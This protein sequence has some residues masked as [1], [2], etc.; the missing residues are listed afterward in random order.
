MHESC[1]LV[2]RVVPGVAA[3]VHSVHDR[4]VNLRLF[5]TKIESKSCVFSEFHGWL[6]AAAATL[7]SAAGSAAATLQIFPTF[8][9]KHG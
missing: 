8:G 1:T 3:I 2:Q 5:F 9:R 6:R 4:L 7:L